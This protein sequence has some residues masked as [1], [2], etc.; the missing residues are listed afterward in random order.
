M[1]SIV[2]LYI[3]LIQ[4]ITFNI[5]LYLFTK[6]YKYKYPFYMPV[7]ILFTFFPFQFILGL[8]SVRAVFRL[9]TNN[10]AWEKTQH[11]NA[12]RINSYQIKQS[13]QPATI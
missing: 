2:P 1:F 7:K 3:L 9:I 4:F 13:Y 8:S 12:H 5:G 10:N 6:D 11:V